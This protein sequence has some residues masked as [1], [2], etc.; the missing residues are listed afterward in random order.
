MADQLIHFND[1]D[2]YQR[3]M[4]VWSQL[5]GEQFLDWLALSSGLRWIDIGCGNG[6]FTELLIQRCAPA[7]TY[8]VDPSE[9]Q[10]AFARGRATA[11]GAN[12]L[13][14][15]AL[16]LPFPNDRF[17]AAV[18]ALV[19]F[20]L[21]DP[22]KGVAEMARVVRPGG[23]VATY[24]WDMLGGGFPWEPIHA[25]MREMGITPLLPPTVNASRLDVL[26][27]LWT[28]AGMEAVEVRPITVQR[29]FTSFDAF[30]NTTTQAA[31]LQPTL[32]TLSSEA[33]ERLKAQVQQRLST[34]S[35]RH[36]AY[37]ASANAIT[38]RVPPIKL[39]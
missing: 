24:V 12:F 20:F 35:E 34:S 23:T 37:S 21:P 2:V 30:W 6:A 5:V 29:T 17:D 39:M 32:A 36:V 28:S 27:D 11:R 22:A 16:E 25:V 18:M 14:G 9:A 26:R 7:E 33:T 31:S 19:I 3:T 15:N 1:G 38:G 10:L 13:Q 8:G 4:G